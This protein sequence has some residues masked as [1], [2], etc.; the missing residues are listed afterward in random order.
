MTMPDK[1]I[2]PFRVKQAVIAL[3]LGDTDDRLL[4]YLNFMTRQVPFET[5]HFI[6]V[7]PT[8]DLFNSIFKREGK[9]MVSNFEL[10]E[11][12]INEMKASLQEELSKQRIDN[13]VFDVREGNPLE[14]LVKEVEETEADLVIIGQS[15]AIGEHGILAR[16]LARK[17]NCNAF[18]V[19]EGSTNKLRK[20]LVPIDFSPHSIQAFKRAVGISKQLD[21]P[22][23][24]VCLNI[25]E[26]PRMAETY[27][28]KTREELQDIVE[29]DRME[30]FKLFLENYGADQAAN[31][32][33]ELIENKLGD[34]GTY[35]MDFAQDNEADMIVIGAKGHSRVERL[36]LGS[37]TERLLSENETIPTL[38]VK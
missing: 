13:I 15:S 7:L 31:V 14:E 27:I 12:T 4:S 9:S 33:T 8:F 17:M 16:N 11:A 37:V 18:I 22:A 32:K 21:A 19:P 36:L 38:V 34:I 3:K 30:S 24:I 6:H 1:T 10:N 2:S 25:Y 28:G 20:I 26:T 23:E 35:I 29:K 5:A